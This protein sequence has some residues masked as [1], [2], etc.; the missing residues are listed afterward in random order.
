VSGDSAGNGVF[1]R[2]EESQIWMA[3]ALVAT[4]LPSGKR[5]LPPLSALEDVEFGDMNS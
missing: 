5:P 4:Y 3:P 2:R 1:V